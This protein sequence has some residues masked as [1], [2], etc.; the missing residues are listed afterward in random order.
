MA[1]RKKLQVSHLLHKVLLTWAP[2]EGHT[3]EIN[4][5]EKLYPEIRWDCILLGENKFARSRPVKGPALAGGRIRTHRVVIIVRHL[6]E[7]LQTSNPDKSKT[8]DEVIEALLEEQKKILAARKELQEIQKLRKAKEKAEEKKLEPKPAKAK[9][10]K[11][12][13]NDLWGVWR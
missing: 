6:R 8:P 2:G 10:P 11:A 3:V 7:W 5:L 1:E 4:C 12:T 13:N 9:A